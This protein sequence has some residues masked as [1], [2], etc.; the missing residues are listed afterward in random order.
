MLGALAQ[1]EP[2]QQEYADP[3]PAC[4]CRRMAGEPLCADGVNKHFVAGVQTLGAVRLHTQ[5]EHVHQ[6]KETQHRGHTGHRGNV[7]VTHTRHTHGCRERVAHLEQAEVDLLVVR[8]LALPVL[9]VKHAAAVQALVVLH[10]AF[11]QPVLEL[12]GGR[13]KGGRGA[14]GW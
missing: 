4:S 1:Q 14:Q 12:K 3:V 9:D 8:G 13:E 5:A 6:C 11:E 2:G 7:T 10:R